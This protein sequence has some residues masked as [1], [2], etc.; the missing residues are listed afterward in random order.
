[1]EKKI[2]CLFLLLICCLGITAATDGDGIASLAEN[3]PLSSTTSVSSLPAMADTVV[4]TVDSVPSQKPRKSFFRPVL[5]GIKSFIREF[6]TFDT[7]YI[8]PQHYKFQVMWQVSTLFENFRLKTGHGDYVD[9]SPD[10]VTRMGPYIGYSLIFLGYT[11]QLNNLYIGNTKK[12]FNLSLY[13]SLFGVDFYYR[14][15]SKFKIRRVFHDGEELRLPDSVYGQAFNGFNVKYW[16]FNT[17]YI[18]NHRKHSYPASYNQSTCQKRSA[19]SPLAGFG[20]GKYNLS[21]NWKDF[22]TFTDVGNQSIGFNGD[23]FFN[24]IMYESYSLYGG[25]SY[26]WV[27][28]HNWTFGTSATIAVSYNKSS[29]ERFRMNKFFED[30]KFSNICL[31]GVGRVGVVWNNTRFFAGAL[32]QIHSYNYSKEQFSLNN[33][34]G[35]VNIYVGLNIGKKKAYRKPGKWFEF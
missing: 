22:E 17:Y 30:F 5:N 16:G 4:T 19:G 29:G 24:E 3:A 23:N 11:L 13:T 9:L 34:F 35:N 15:N 10:V 21:M 33:T 1:M 20:Y 18:F 32:A 14:D 2:L 25:Y 8:E 28:A 6:K 26:N 7:L 31:D 12:S 27:F